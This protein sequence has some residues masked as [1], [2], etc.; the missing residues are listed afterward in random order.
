MKRI[1]QKPFLSY[2]ILF[3]L[4]FIIATIP[5]QIR[6]NTFLGFGLFTDGF[7]Q[8]L[9]FMRDF[10]SSIKDAIN[11]FGFQ[12]FRYD[13]GLGGDFI[14]SYTYYSLF[15]PLTFI[16]YLLPN[17][18]IEFSYYLIGVLRLYL[19]GIVIIL[20]AKS[21]QIK[22]PLALLAVGIFYVFNVTVIYSALRHPMFVN[23]PLLFPLIIM[24]VERVWSGKNPA[25]LLIASFLA[26]ITQFYFFMFACVGFELFVLIRIVLINKSNS[27]KT[28]IAKFFQ[29]NMIYLLG[30]L[31]ASF[32]LF[33]QL[34]ATMN[35]GRIAGKGLVFYD[36]LDYASYLASFMVPVIGAHYTSAIGNIVVLVIVLA[37]IYTHRSSWEGILFIVLSLMML[38]SIFGFAFN[39][40]SYVNNRWTFLLVLPA[41]IML[42]KAIEHPEEIPSQAVIRAMQI[43]LFLL[44]LVVGFAFIYVSTFLSSTLITILVGVIVLGLTIYLFP[45]VFHR[46]LGAKLLRYFTQKNM[47]RLTLITSFVSVLIIASIYFFTMSASAGLSSYEQPEVFPS[48]Q[49][50]SSYYRVEQKVYALGTNYLAN[51]NLVSGYNSTYCYNTMSSGYVNQVISY[52]DVVNLNSTAGYNG[53][54]NRSALM[55]INHVKYIIIRDSEKTPVP[56]GFSLVEKVTVQKTIEG[57]YNAVDIGYLDIQNGEV[58]TEEASIYRND[59][60]VPF[61]FVY[62]EVVTPDDLATLSSVEKEQVLLS[63]GLVEVETGLPKHTITSSL[64]KNDVVI[65]D[66]EGITLSDHSFTAYQNDARLSFIVQGATNHEL[67]VELANLRSQTPKKEFTITYETSDCL[68]PEATYGDGTNFEFDNPNHL[69]NL[70][71]CQEGTLTVTLHVPKGTYFYDEFSYYLNP[72]DDYDA[73]I[74]DLNDEVLTNL[75]FTSNGFQGNIVLTNQG[76]LNISLP[77][78]DGFT[79]YVDDLA[80]PIIHTNIGY[81]GIVVAAGSHTIRF[82]YHTPGLRL[83][84]ILSVIALALAFFLIMI[85]GFWQKYQLQGKTL[86]QYFNNYFNSNYFLTITY[87]LVVICWVINAPIVAMAYISLSSILIIVTNSD[88]VN[89]ASLVLSALIIPRSEVYNTN[90]LIYFLTV[91]VGLPF[92]LYD[93]IKNK[94]RFKDP[95]F[96]ALLA[97]VVANAL[98]LMNAPTNEFYFALMGT[99]VFFAY[100]FIYWYFRP[101]A[102]VGGEL[103]IMKNSFA[104]G[105]AITIQFVY[106][107]L[108]YD[109]QIIGKDLD[110]SWAI[111]NGIAMLC[112][113]LIPLNIALYI[114][115]QKHS[116][117][118]LGV[119]GEV[120]VLFLTLSKGAYIS[121]ALISIPTFIIMWKYTQN[122]KKLLVDLF[123]SILIIGII[124]WG[125]TQID[126]VSV[127]IAQYLESMDARGWFN[128]PSRLEIYKKGW[129]AFLDNPLFGRG[130]STTVPDASFTTYHNFII[131]TLATTGIVG[132]LAFTF[133]LVSL[134]YTCWKKNPYHLMILMCIIAMCIHGMVDNSFYFPLIMIF[135]STVISQLDLTN[136]LFPLGKKPTL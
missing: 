21:F 129:Q 91:G 88:R 100:F 49:N 118:L 109:G 110:F 106:Y 54:N 94:Y 75:T 23:G 63:A 64:V 41:T 31:V 18:A 58:Q 112:L 32:I 4:F 136:K 116:F 57:R 87:L 117:V 84:L 9:I 126:K 71:Y 42:G 127:G 89:I 11:G 14:T 60:F 111:S 53:F 130:T 20:C 61:G 1:L 34:I 93:I 62:H 108:T 3:F 86:K 73:I 17:Q 128:D 105:M 76:L 38:V 26:L 40:F 122:H 92:L 69:V 45:K 124:A 12:W 77:F 95:I 83:G 48:I 70:G 119:I 56:Y 113:V 99:F 123:A 132:A 25:L 72:M 13:L 82:E 46:P 90:V 15:D 107:I 22:A 51:D 29:V 131:H 98:S 5:A 104:L 102:K 68:V 19:C 24:G 8:H 6:S 103:T 39:L 44:I 28:V 125:I 120:I 37:Y 27:W 80:T 121:L 59:H 67:F 35:S 81:M 33:P 50:D 79:A 65:G 114:T 10:T 30:A 74:D 115:H 78:H 55:S 47:T 96:Y 101:N 7:K 97:M 133:Y 134:V 85:C 2:T 52:Y 66:T 135:L 43:V 16:A 36:A